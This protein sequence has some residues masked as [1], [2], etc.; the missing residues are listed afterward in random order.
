MATESV[1]IKRSSMGKT[2]KKLVIKKGISLVPSTYKK[3]KE[4]DREKIIFSGYN[5]LENLVIVR[6]YIQKIYDIDY[7]VLETLIYL[8]PKTFF[9]YEDYKELDKQY[10]IARVRRL[11]DLGL[12]TLVSKGGRGGKALFTL[13]DRSRKIVIDFYDKLLGNK[14][15]DVIKASKVFDETKLGEGK[16]LNLIKKL[17]EKSRAK[18]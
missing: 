8:H 1:Y 14:P 9:T 11:T 2:A 3:Y 18:S 12:A 16:T 6:K 7:S 4:W 13:S 15:M 17:E 5:C 10:Q